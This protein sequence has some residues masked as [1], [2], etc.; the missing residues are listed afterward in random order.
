MKRKISQLIIFFSLIAWNANSQSSDSLSLNIKDVKSSGVILKYFGDDT[1]TLKADGDLNINA[2]RWKLRIASNQNVY[3]VLSNSE[4]EG[5]LSDTLD[6]NKTYFIERNTIVENSFL[7]SKNLSV[8]VFNKANNKSI[9]KYQLEYNSSNKTAGKISSSDDADV[10]E[11]KVGSII[12]DALYLA[13]GSGSI[14]KKNKILSYYAPNKTGDDWK[15]SYAQ[16]K[17]LAPIVNEFLGEADPQ[18]FSGLASVFSSIGGLDVTSFADGAAKFMVKRAKQ[19]LSI[20]FFRKFKNVIRDTRDIGT[21]FPQT[22][23][24]LNAM[25]EEIYE[26]EKYL[27][28]LREAFKRDITE[29]HR[30]LPGIVDNHPV[31]FNNHQP[32]KA[33]LLSAC[34]TALEL[35][36]QS[37][38]GDI[39]AAYPVEYL[40]G[41]T[42]KNYKGAIQTV[43]LLSASLRD[44]ATNKDANYWVNI[45]L[46]RQLIND[47]RT[48]GIYLGLLLQEAKNKYE[49][50]PFEGVT[51]ANLL[52]KV[53]DNYE[54]GF[55]VY[56]SYRNYILRFGEKTDALN[57]MIKEYSEESTL[58]SAVIEKYAKYFRTAV[59]L[60][61]YS[62]QTSRL[63]VIK[64]HLPDLNVLL[65]KYFDVAYSVS[66]LVVDVNRKNYSAVINHT[67]HIYNV[68]TVRA[69]NE[70]STAMA[71]SPEQVA[72]ERIFKNSLNR[73]VRYGSFMATVATAKN[74]DEVERAIEAA[75]LPVGSSRIKRVSDFN[76]SLNSYAGLFYGVERIQD[77]DSGSFKPN[78]FGVTAPIGVAASWGH[79]FLFFKTQNEWS[80]SLFVSLI[81]LGA[82]AAF[83]FRDDSTAQIP[84]I[85]LRNIFSPGAFLSL[86]IPK[87]PLSFSLGAQVGPNLRKVSV[88]PDKGN[89]F[90]DKI[91]WRFSTSLAVDIPIFNF[92]TR[93]R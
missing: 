57:K 27:Q 28:N 44:T 26:Y 14:G 89:D 20:A 37:H 71:L 82:V 33:A 76:V 77:L 55:S 73:L 60:V 12:H 39:L 93:S 59:D 64:D 63:P 45:K 29:I 68:V 9:K 17:F 79:R 85:R 61:E 81:D 19:E 49:D 21:V 70:V 11:Y 13:N 47:K 50:L 36:N 54:Q 31:F 3:V 51:L 25:D 84:T 32:V 8:E 5:R 42:N 4:G 15:A 34:Y 23:N 46:V 2:D 69:V 66:D 24:L 91:Y 30:N 65:S 18:S 40:N 41:I 62:T 83:R 80:T 88:D 87:T 58:D 78:V 22:A 43:Q 16:N 10:D 52:N 92:H 7:L 90:S 35:E 56:N 74:S 67:V 38:P 72:D 6:L 75:A 53:A 86:G 1:I 48:L